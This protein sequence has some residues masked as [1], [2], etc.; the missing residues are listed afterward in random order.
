MK[1][2]IMAAGLLSLSSVAFSAQLSS[3][4]EDY[5]KQVDEYVD[6]LSKNDVTKGQI[7]TM[8]QQYTDSKKQFMQLPADAQDTACKQGLDALAQAKTMMEQQMAK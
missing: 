4:C 3:V 7:D 6:L 5:F 2:L 8:K 1:K